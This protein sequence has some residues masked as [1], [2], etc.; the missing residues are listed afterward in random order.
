MV[1]SA[2]V[3]DTS[4]AYKEFIDKFGNTIPKGA[5]KVRLQ[6]SGNNTLQAK[7][8][9]AYP[10]NV[11]D[12]EVPLIGEHVL[13]HTSIGSD[14]NIDRI[15]TK[16]YY[17]KAVNSN[18]NLNH[19]IMAGYINTITKSNGVSLSQGL[20]NT[21]A[22]PTTE[23]KTLT[24]KIQDRSFLQPY[25]G[26]R[27]IQSRNGSAIRF[28]S[29]VLGNLSTYSLTPSWSG[30]RNGDPL[31]IIS[32]GI[33]NNNVTQYNIEDI[34]NDES[35]VYLT[36]SQQ[37]KLSLSQTRTA[38][39]LL[40]T[41]IYN[42]SQLIGNASRILLNAKDDAVILSGK[43]TVSISTPRWAVDMDKF[44]TQVDIMQQQ[45]IQLTAQ[46]T[47]LTTLINT[48]AI[49]DLPAATALSALGIVLPSPATLSSGTPVITGQLSS[50]TSQLS[51]VTATLATLKQ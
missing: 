30:T 12:F 4:F 5:I 1:V 37:I 49:S 15:R 11:N 44:F 46:V 50:I 18:S 36:S 38:I 31:I 33:K 35:S 32:N 25:E 27:I 20:R 48:A 43:R 14:T 23:K 3:I 2:E 40:D 29:S 10:L 17:S 26:D 34:N 28:T 16:Y 45:L 21:S 9:F 6:E 7:D 22:I 19:N 51:N 13:L 42:K 8:T 24:F 47:A 39:G 41:S